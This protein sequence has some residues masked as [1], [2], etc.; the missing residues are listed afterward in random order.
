MV[1][2]SDVATAASLRLTDG[3]MKTSDGNNLPIVNGMFAAGDARVAENFALTSLHT[4]FVREHNYQ[5]DKLH[6]QH[7]GWGGDRLYDSAR[8][9][10]TAEIENIT[11]REFLPHLLGSEAVAPYRGYQSRRRSKPHA[12]VQH[13][14]SLRTF[15]RV[16]G[17]RKPG[18]ERRGGRRIRA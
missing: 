11:Y 4:L 17:D 12:R 13:R 5:V 7:P 8:A 2:G 1:Y 10:V 18:G 9:I 14:L 3:H 15:D 6:K 16:G